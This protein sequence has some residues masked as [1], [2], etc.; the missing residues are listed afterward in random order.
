VWRDS[1]RDHPDEE[2]SRISMVERCSVADSE[3]RAVQNVDRAFDGFF[4]KRSGFPRF[5]KKHSSVQSFRIPQNIKVKANVG[6]HSDL[7]SRVS[8][9]RASS[10][11]FQG[12]EDDLLC[13]ERDNAFGPSSTLLRRLSKESIVSVKHDELRSLRIQQ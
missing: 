2:N 12:A 6:G 9:R 13:R 8:R 4:E 1:K 3:S 5:K 7:L 10:L 11:P